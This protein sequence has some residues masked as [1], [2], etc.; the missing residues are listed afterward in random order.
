MRTAVLWIES[1][2]WSSLLDYYTHRGNSNER[3]FSGL[4]KQIAKKVGGKFAGLGVIWS[5]C[6][7][8]DLARRKDI[9][10]SLG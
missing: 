7:K 4:Q 5:L 10:I 9:L 2:K 6:L 1:R 3:V 8:L